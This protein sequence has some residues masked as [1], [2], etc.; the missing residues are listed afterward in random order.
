MWHTQGSGKSLTMVMLAKAIALEPSITE[1]KI[2][3]VTDRVDLDDQI[4]RTFQ[5]CGRD[6]EQAR[7]GIHLLDMLQSKK[8]RIITTVIDKFEAAVGKQD[9]RNEDSDIFVLVDE[10][11][12]VNM[13]RVM[14]KCARFSPTPAISVLPAHR[15]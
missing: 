8:Q 15:S 5:H 7:T 12:R 6:T 10:G 13:V 2:I 11:H 14:P 1:H 3:L 4:Y 9:A